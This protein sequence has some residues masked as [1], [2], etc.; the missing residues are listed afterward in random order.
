MWL[1]VNRINLVRCLW[2]G[3]WWKWEDLQLHK[4]RP[5]NVATLLRGQV[6]HSHSAHACCNEAVGFRV[7]HFAQSREC[8][9]KESVWTVTASE[10]RLSNVHLWRRPSKWRSRAHLGRTLICRLPISITVPGYRCS[11]LRQ[12]RLSLN[13]EHYM[14]LGHVVWKV[15]LLGSSLV[16]SFNCDPR[17][18]R[19]YVSGW[20]ENAAENEEDQDCVF[21]VFGGGACC[22]V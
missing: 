4:G 6:L 13:L 12:E 22:Q 15:C 9:P 21:G 20:M 5:S 19:A 11:I 8:E 16:I 14:A 10:D 2:L 17:R 18:R 1:M 3:A 7:A